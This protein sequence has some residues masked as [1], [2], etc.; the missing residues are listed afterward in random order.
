MDEVKHNLVLVTYTS[1]E[2]F[3][4]LLETVGSPVRLNRLESSRP[5]PAG[6]HITPYVIIQLRIDDELNLLKL[7]GETYDYWG[8]QF[9]EHRLQREQAVEW[10]KNLAAACL[11]TFMRQGVTVIANSHYPHPDL[12]RAAGFHSGRDIPSEFN[13]PA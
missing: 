8:D 13:Q 7:I 2:P 11:R 5:Y 4:R 12:Y 9:D 10:L 3:F 6:A 1:I